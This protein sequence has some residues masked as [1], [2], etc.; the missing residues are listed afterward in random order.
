VT[1][2]GVVG[3]PGYDELRDVL[4]Q[5]GGIARRL[6]IRLQFESELRGMTEDGE[7]LREIDGL[8]ALLTL[9]GDGTLLRGARLVGERPIPIIGINMGRLGFLT[10]CGSGEIEAAL[11][12]FQS[13]DY[14]AESRMALSARVLAVDG[15]ERES[16]RAM[17]D[18]VVH[19]GGFARVVRLTV[20]AD[21]APVASYAADGVVIA[22]PTGS[23]AY[24]LSA[25]GPVV[26]PTLDVLLVTPI[27]A[28]T[29][30]IRPLVLS[31]TS[32]IVVRPDDAPEELMVTV[33]GQGGSTLGVGETLVVARAA[34]GV[35]IVR[36]P[37]QSFF[38][39]L[40]QKLGWG[41]LHQAAGRVQG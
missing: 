33:D 28:H 17:N 20:S 34:A 16:W 21:D 14:V 36:F 6:G 4:Q 32:E 25:G 18:V 26:V 41:G 5:L 27:S 29:L 38:S 10:C 39:T 7:P 13:G 8:D 19:K 22:S 9:G 1:R 37:G 24:S 30:G 12:R 15:T 11:E 31:A 2:V 35:I 40:R 23:T 3:N